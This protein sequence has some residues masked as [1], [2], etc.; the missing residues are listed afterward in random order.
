MLEQ[1]KACE[2]KLKSKRNMINNA[3]NENK[4]IEKNI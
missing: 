3:R 2:V 1:I 4:K